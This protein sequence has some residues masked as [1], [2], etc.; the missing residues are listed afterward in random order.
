MPDDG[1]AGN[2]A[3]GG[4]PSLGSGSEGD[5]QQPLVLKAGS[6]VKVSATVQNW[7]P[8]KV[9]DQDDPT[10][11]GFVFAFSAHPNGSNF[12]PGKPRPVTSDGQTVSTNLTVMS[13]TGD[14]VIGM[15]FCDASGR[16]SPT[17]GRVLRKC[18]FQ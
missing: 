13:F 12:T 3:T 8:E 4:Q 14:G 6:T 9:A 17:S 10:V 1:N 2:N 11:W 18:V 5:D 15:T 7:S 16:A